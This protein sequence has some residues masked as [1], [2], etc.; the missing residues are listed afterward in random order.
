MDDSFAFYD[1]LELPFGSSVEAVKK[2]WRRLSLKYH[3]DK[4]RD[5]ESR[6]FA[7][8]IF[9]RVRLAYETLSDA[10]TRAIYDS[11]DVRLFR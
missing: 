6:R 10:A 4:Q 8:S 7:A 3:P 9:S 5:E 1:H 11:S 2:S